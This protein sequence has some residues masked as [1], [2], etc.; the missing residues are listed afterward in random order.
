ME[1]IDY[2]GIECGDRNEEKE[3]MEYSVSK[4]MK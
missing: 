3:R 1:R 2:T 4:G